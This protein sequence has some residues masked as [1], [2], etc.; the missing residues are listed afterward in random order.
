[1]AHLWHAR[2]YKLRWPKAYSCN[3]GLVMEEL[4]YRGNWPIS[5]YFYTFF[6][7]W[8]VVPYHLLAT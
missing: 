1:M 7:N 2:H 6:L 5:Y 8:L 3:Y 4:P